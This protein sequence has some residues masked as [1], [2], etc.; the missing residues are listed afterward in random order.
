MVCT[1]LTH[2]AA[3][4]SGQE[5]DV[6]SDEADHTKPVKVYV[7]LGQSN[8]LGFGRVGPKETIGSLEV[9]VKE[10]GKYSHL[11]DAAGNWITR[12]DVRYVHVMDQRGVDY[13][14]MEVCLTRESRPPLQS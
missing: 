14:N 3:G 10:K 11:V 7:M 9:M 12:T 2:S 5:S 1:L 6:V 8:M 13:K 4:V